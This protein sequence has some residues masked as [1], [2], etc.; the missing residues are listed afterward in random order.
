MNPQRTEPIRAV[1]DDPA[2]GR[3][4]DPLRTTWR[5]GVG[6]RGPVGEAFDVLAFWLGTLLFVVTTLMW[7]V[8]SVPLR[9]L[10]P[11]AIG[12]RLGQ[13]GIMTVFR[14]N[15]GYWRLTR[16][17]DLDLGAL[18]ALRS[19][20]GLVIAPNH[21][22]LL[23]VTLVTSR[24][25]RITCIMKGNLRY[26]V[27]LDDGARLARYIR[28]DSPYGMVKRAV[29]EI[30]RGHQLLVFPEGTRTVQAPVNRFKPGFALIAQ[31]ARVPV[32]TVFIETDSPFLCKGWPRW[33]RPDLPIRYR[34]RLGRRFT[35]EGDVKA[36]TAMLER[37]F[38]EELRGRPEQV[39]PGRPNV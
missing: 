3:G 22:T 13:R 11:R 30:G 31:R 33:R 12:T 17:F 20:G 2:T 1:F 29:E 23:D 16:R 5:P 39:P 18:D 27:L 37:Y 8:C 25:S 21:P 14:M 4:S 34:V 24:L 32:Q 10:L 26:N 6:G 9:W 19:E 15:L 28:N 7:S 35:V 36:F 38:V